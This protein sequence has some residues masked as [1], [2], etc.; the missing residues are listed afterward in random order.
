MSGDPTRMETAGRLCENGHRWSGSWQPS[1]A[2]FWSPSPSTCSGTRT[3]GS[4]ESITV[5]GMDG[6]K[7]G[8][9]A[10]RER[11][12]RL[13]SSVQSSICMLR[14]TRNSVQTRRAIGTMAVPP[15]STT[16]AWTSISPPHLPSEILAPGFHRRS[17]PRPWQTPNPTSVRRTGGRACCWWSSENPGISSRM[18]LLPR[19][20]CRRSAWWR[21]SAI[22]LSLRACWKSAFGNEISGAWWWRLGVHAPWSSARS[23][24]RPIWAL[25]IFGRPSRGGSS[26]STWGSPPSWLRCW[27]GWAANTGNGRSWSISVSWDYLVRMQ[28]LSLMNGP[29]ATDRGLHGSL[30]QGRRLTSL[31]HPV[32][33]PDFSG[34]LSSHLHPGAHRIAPDSISEPCPAAIRLHASDPHAVRSFHSIRH[35]RKRNP[36]SRLWE[37]EC[38]TVRQ[39]H[40]R[41]FLDVPWGILDY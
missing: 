27:C 35:H 36:L 16:T 4:N 13:R 7:A 17:V 34:G 33:Y 12:A 29:D 26:S 41:L 28:L 19:L 30:H 37:S 24:P 21:W 15:K 6:R 2:M 25:K 22:A 5:S 31:R 20:L 10:T 1:W 40:R 3:S 18:D 9:G 23:V 11:W 14:C 39:V 38:R 32:A 8:T